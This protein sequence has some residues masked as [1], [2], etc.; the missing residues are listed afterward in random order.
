[1]KN[2]IKIYA[3][4][5]LFLSDFVALAQPGDDDDNNDLEGND[6]VPVNSKIVLLLVFGIVLAYYSFK[7]YSKP[8]SE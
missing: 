7:K 4:A 2:F 6:P 8:V 3:F 5:F 1:M